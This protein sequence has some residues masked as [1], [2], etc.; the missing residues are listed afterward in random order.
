[1]KKLNILSIIT[2]TIFFLTGTLYSQG[3]IESPSGKEINTTA[4]IT[5]K[6][7]TVT[8]STPISGYGKV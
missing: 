7:Q 4:P 6:Q 2:L 8:P 3:V 1:M 5:M